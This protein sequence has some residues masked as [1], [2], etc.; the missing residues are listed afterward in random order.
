MHWVAFSTVYRL[1]VAFGNHSTT[2]DLGAEYP[3]DLVVFSHRLLFFVWRRKLLFFTQFTGLMDATQELGH[4]CATWTKTSIFWKFSKNSSF[5]PYFPSHSLQIFSTMHTLLN[6]EIVLWGTGVGAGN[7]LERKGY[8][9]RISQNF[10][11]K[12]LCDKFSPW[13]YYL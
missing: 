7:F 6:L 1:F 5:Y 11:E 4:L 12:L 9:A 8:F 13:N 2:Q 10:L 3:R